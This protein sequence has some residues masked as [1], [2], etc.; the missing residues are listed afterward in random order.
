MKPIETKAVNCAIM[1]VMDFWNRV[2]ILR[3]QCHTTYRKLAAIMGFSE[4]TVSS[5]RRAGTEPRAGDAVKIA[6]E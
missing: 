2:E 1:Q 5:M 6:R 3:K 4:T